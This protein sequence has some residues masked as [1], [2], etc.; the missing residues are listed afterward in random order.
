M[1]HSEKMLLKLQE[2]TTNFILYKLY[3]IDRIIIWIRNYTVRG[4]EPSSYSVLYTVIYIV[5]TVHCV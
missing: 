2:E 4:E 5:S 3:N 1:V